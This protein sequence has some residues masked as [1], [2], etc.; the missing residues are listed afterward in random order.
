MNSTHLPSSRVCLK[1]AVSSGNIIFALINFFLAVQQHEKK[2]DLRQ[3]LF[4]IVIKIH[5]NCYQGEAD[6]PSYAFSIA[7][8]HAGLL[9]FTELNQ[10]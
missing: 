5:V 10:P 2:T 9:G 7:L 4:F 8:I 1:L 6:T 3:N